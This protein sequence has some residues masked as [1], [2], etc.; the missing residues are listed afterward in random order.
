MSITDTG[1][2]RCFH[3]VR[4][5]LCWMDSR[6][7]IF[8]CYCW[9]LL[10]I[11]SVEQSLGYYFYGVLLQGDQ[12]FGCIGFTFEVIL[13]FL[14]LASTSNST[15]I[16]VV[17]ALLQWCGFGSLLVHSSSWSCG[18]FLADQSKA[19][20]RVCV[21]LLLFGRGRS[22]CSVDSL[23]VRCTL[24]LFCLVGVGPGPGP[25]V[26]PPCQFDFLGP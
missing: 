6:C 12:S 23:G 11:L 1:V 8:D 5:L 26:L 9:D 25:C 7:R 20:E 3:L 13:F 22:G 14:F 17:S 10:R 2:V 15:N 24:T 4:S 21:F 16:S 18:H 19:G